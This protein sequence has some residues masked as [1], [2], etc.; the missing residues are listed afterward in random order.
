MLN[1]NINIDLKLL[2][3]LLEV[4]GGCRKS[5]DIVYIDE[6][7]IRLLKE[8]Y[9][10]VRELKKREDVE[11]VEDIK[12]IIEVVER[13]FQENSFICI[14]GKW[15]II[16]NKKPLEEV[17]EKIK[18]VESLKKPFLITSIEF[19]FLTEE[20]KDRSKEVEKDIMD[21][22]LSLQSHIQVKY[23]SLI[24]LTVHAEQLYN[25]DRVN[26][27]EAIKKRIKT[28][29]GDFGLM[30]CNLY[31]RNY[32]KKFLKS[33]KGK[34]SVTIEKEINSFFEDAR[35]IFFIHSDMSLED[36]ESIENQ[37]KLA[38]NDNCEYVA[39]HSLG[40]ATV[41]A[42]MIVKKIEEKLHISGYNRRKIDEA[43]GERNIR[44]F[45]VIW[46]KGKK[47][48]YFLHLFDC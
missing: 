43:K 47:G 19:G 26:D 33:M 13:F 11:R 4:L 32:L 15:Y 12:K 7:T 41:F 20:F 21:V 29:Y 28:V 30:F 46:Y 23:K 10:T 38:F 24:S 14:E 40:G 22:V 48:E 17:I 8:W 2:E 25:E 6:E 39:I 1:I 42:E 5:N 34:D 35:R 27:A 31:Q 18:S 9:E 45:T 16:P 3:K 36:L 37:I 44:D